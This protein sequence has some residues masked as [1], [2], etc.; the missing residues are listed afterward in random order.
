MQKGLSD[1]SWPHIWVW[2]MRGVTKTQ[3]EEGYSSG[4]ITQ[5]MKAEGKQDGNACKK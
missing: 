3:Q 5:Q 4:E 1:D 2:H